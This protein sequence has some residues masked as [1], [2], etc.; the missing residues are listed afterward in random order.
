VTVACT[1]TDECVLGGLPCD[2]LA[3]SLLNMEEELKQ[4]VVG[5]DAAITEIANCIRL[6]RA[7]LRFHDRPLGCFLLCGP[8]GTGKTELAKSLTKYLFHDPNAM[9]RAQLTYIYIYTPTLS[10]VFT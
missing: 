10:F 1:C 2:L 8:T 6:S 7:G 5:Q 3:G 9:V 4:R